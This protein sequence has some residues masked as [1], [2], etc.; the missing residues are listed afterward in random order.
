MC[1]VKAGGERLLSSFP[2]DQFHSPT[3]QK[4]PHHYQHIPPKLRGAS[5]CIHLTHSELELLGGVHGKAAGDEF[6][7][8]IS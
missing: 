3:P 8:E 5:G 4:I 1:Q 7:G 6:R 2:A